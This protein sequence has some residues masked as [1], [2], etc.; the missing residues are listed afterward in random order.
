ME[1]VHHL[2]VHMNDPQK[3]FLYL[4]LAVD[5]YKV[6][7]ANSSWNLILKHENEKGKKKSV[8]P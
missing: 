2:V 5:S 7:A 8:I 1:P 4:D 3:E 6:G